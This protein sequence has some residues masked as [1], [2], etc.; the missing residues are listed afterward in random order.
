MGKKLFLAFS[1]LVL[2]IGR[3]AYVKFPDEVDLPIGIKILYG[4]LVFLENT[5]S[6]TYLPP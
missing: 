6:N 3:A 1:L 2:L 5:V 4:F